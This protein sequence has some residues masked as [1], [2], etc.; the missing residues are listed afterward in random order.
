MGNPT[1]H[2]KSARRPFGAK[3]PLL[4]CGAMSLLPVGSVMAQTP[5]PAAGA[6]AGGQFETVVVTARRR[7]EDIQK[8]PQAVTAFGAA[9]LQARGIRTEEDLQ[10]STPGL[11]LRQTEGQN[12]L[13]YSIRGQTIDGFSGSST[14]VVPYINEVQLNSQGAGSFLDLQSIQVLKGPQGTL[15][16]R[17]AT[18]GAVLYTTVKP[19]DTFGG[20]FQLSGGNY[21]YFEGQGALNIPVSDKILMRFAVDIANRDGYQTNVFNGQRLGDMRRQTGRFSLILRPTERL[22]NTLVVE[23]GHSGG[24]N[25]SVKA[26]SVYQPG[27]RGPDGSLLTAAATAT[28]NPATFNFLFG[29]GA[30]DAYLAGNPGILRAQPNAATVG[31]PGYLAYQN[32]Q[33]FYNVGTQVGSQHKQKNYYAT[34]T[35]TFDLTDN[36]QLK[37]IAGFSY[38]RSL[39]DAGEIGVPYGIQFTDNLNL[40][41]FGNNVGVKSYSEELQLQGKALDQSL[42]YV[43]G[44]YYQHTR[45]LTFYPQTYFTFAPLAPGTGVTS[46]YR[47]ENTN[48][49]I[50]AQGTYD[51]SKMGL[52]GLKFTAGARYSWE[53]VKQQHLSGSTNRL[54][55]AGQKVTFNK[56]SWTVG[57]DYSV[58][59][60][61]MIYATSRGSWRSGGLNGNA[62]PRNFTAAGAG[63]IFL[64][65]TTKDV[66]VG[67]KGSHDIMGRPAH[68]NV[69][70]YKQWIK[71]VQRSEFP[72]EP[73]TGNSIAVTINV[74]SAVVKGIEADMAISPSQ[75]LTIG[76]SG[77]YTDAQYIDKTSLIFGTLYVFG[78]YADTPK[79]SGT[80]Y[81]VLTL[82]VSPDIGEM[83]IRA[84]AYTQSPQYFSN[85][86]DSFIPGTKLPA[87]TIVNLR[88]DWHDI[89]GSKV[90]LGA[91]AK[92]LLNEE[93]YTGGL[94][95]GASFGI[96]AAAIGRPRM[97]GFDVRVD[98]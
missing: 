67:L 65:E 57:L 54:G 98:F 36:M 94:A 73:G 75:W 21:S 42:T 37:N 16:G 40:G 1:K 7:S 24:N 53:Q 26:F 66:E 87:Y 97:Y 62:P 14:A 61:L 27:D 77:A 8:V 85:N 39:D 69:A 60:D 63:N 91:F 96:N 4:L 82:P 70:F 79:L 76:A 20:F 78:P 31:L 59:S 83:T 34:N 23:Y 38:D 55:A 80:L 74:P 56:P 15:F 18:G 64:P 30:W 92:N 9:Q 81:T 6:E 58:T 41:Q 49:A 93:Y 95:Q 89:M 72:T 3:A 17:N 46:D 71:G 12:Q 10:I 88:Y 68:F 48:E 45:T 44:T 47:T 29:P 43:V 90:S 5:A 25:T 2:M 19:T 11:T 50:Y 51:F 35:T 13:T 86:A 33:P 52:D 32:T 84:D 28:Y 22:E